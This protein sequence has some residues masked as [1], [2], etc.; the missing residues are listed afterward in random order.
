M[1]VNYFLMHKNIRVAELEISESGN[2]SKIG[3]VFSLKHLPLGTACGD[4][5]AD[6][7]SLDQWWRGR[8]IPASRSGLRD[9]LDYLGIVDTQ[10]L[11]TKC[12]G[13]SLSDQYWVCPK[14]V[15]LDWHQVNFF[16]NSFSSDVGNAL[17]GN[18]PEGVDLDL[19]SPDNTSDGWLRKKWIMS[20]DEKTRHLIKGGSAPFHQ[21]PF[22]EVLAALILERLG[23]P[24]VTY[25]ILPRNS[26]D[27]PYCICPN[28][29]TPQ[30]ELISGWR[31]CSTRK[32]ANHLS[33][34]QHYLSCCEELGIPGIKESLD[35]MLVLD[36]LIVNTDR[37]FN[38]FGVVRNADT[39]AWIGPAPI[40]DSGTSM[41]HNQLT[42][43]IWPRKV[44]E[45]KPFR[46]THQEQLQLVT[47]FDWIRFDAL[48]G[49]DKEYMELLSDSPYLD[50]QRILAL[51]D[52]LRTRIE[53]LYE[54]AKKEK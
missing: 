31:I 24:H 52:S 37:H 16:E 33:A 30:T 34:Y 38:N 15:N 9:M 36:F 6:L 29:I 7:R 5:R 28:F 41:W 46:K 1:P 10:L 11:L 2:I 43:R 25:Q 40:F 20:E 12:M 13:L 35:Q 54:F 53:M 49:I 4:S 32:K 48:D 47:S 23:V 45:S 14:G 17:F 8:S 19:M 26:E 18:F 42:S 51:C 50:E 21:E 3:K 22:N 27:L 44:V 39:L